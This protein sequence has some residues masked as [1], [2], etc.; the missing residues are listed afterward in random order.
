MENRTLLVRLI[1]VCPTKLGDRSAYKNC[2]GIS[3]IDA[4]VKVFV[5]L[6]NGKFPL[7]RD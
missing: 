4:I 5:S 2:C 3:L 6:W 1:Y 7:E